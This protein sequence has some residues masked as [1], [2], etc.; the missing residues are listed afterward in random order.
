MRTRLTT[1][2]AVC[3]LA[4]MGFAK[5]KKKA[6]LPTYVLR[7]QT[8]AIIIDPTAGFTIDD[9]RANEV[10]RQDV[11]SALLSWGRY[12]P[13]LQTNDA[14]LIVVVRK[15]NG[16]M[17]NDTIHDQ[18][19]NNRAGS[20]IP[21]DNGVSISGQHSTPGPPQPS[22]EP[23]PQM[24]VGQTEDSFVVYEGGGDRPLDRAPAWRYIAKDGLMPHS[25]PA[26]D[27]FRKAVADAE[28]A[29]AKTP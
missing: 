21:A 19:Q 25:V 7:A 12:N 23:T 2:I 9:P 10:A 24:D 5:D 1:L 22:P 17:V 27:A 26:V 4:T 13:I 29:A 8:V 20:V 6:T 16:R 15:G 14:D 11:E 18:R 3:L 28:K